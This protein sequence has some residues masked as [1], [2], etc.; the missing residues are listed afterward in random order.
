MCRPFRGSLLF[1]AYPRASARG[2]PL[3]RAC[4]ARRFSLRLVVSPVLANQIWPALSFWRLGSELKSMDRRNAD[5][6]FGSNFL[7]SPRLRASG[8]SVRRKLSENL[9]HQR[10]RVAAVLG[11]LSG[12]ACDLRIG[13]ALAEKA[14]QQGIAQHLN[15]ALAPVGDLFF[16]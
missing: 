2:L 4:G 15:Q 7:F 10:I 5:T 8:A 11:D 9:L 1:C 16:Q 12:Q 14:F 13:Q 6:L 3:F